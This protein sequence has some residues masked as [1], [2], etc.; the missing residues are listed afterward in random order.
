MT[1][2]AQQAKPQVKLKTIALPAQH[3]GWGFLLE[4][5]L[6]GM[7][8]AASWA[9][10]GVSIAALGTFLTHQPLKILVKDRRKGKRYTRTILAERFVLGYGALAVIGLMLALFNSDTPFL[11]PLVGAVPLGVLQLVYE[12][13]ND[14]RNVIAEIAGAVAFG[15]VASMITLCAGWGIT[16]AL[17]LWLILAVRAVVSILYVRAR[18]RL[19][20]SKPAPIVSTIW[21]H[22]AGLIIYT[23]LVVAGYAPWTILLAGSVLL[24]RA[25]YG[26]SPYRKQ[27]SPKV[28]GFSEMAYGLL[29]V[30]LVVIGW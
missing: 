4:P 30:I 2:Q 6:L 29:T 16:S 3:G 26:L 22:V 19:E 14:G 24:G 8:L 15:S 10:L 23:G 20:K 25:G 17:V 28:I 5:I 27:V 12:F 21:W 13:E 9:G 7:L 1:S 18:L 11:L